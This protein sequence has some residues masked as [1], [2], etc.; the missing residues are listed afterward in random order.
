LAEKE[1]KVKNNENAIQRYLRETSGELRKVN[2]PTWPEAKR[3]TGLVLMV[4][5]VVG[6]FL[7]VVDKLSAQ[8]INIILGI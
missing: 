6:I 2:W 1:K 4:M 3:L 7:A 8:L 5:L